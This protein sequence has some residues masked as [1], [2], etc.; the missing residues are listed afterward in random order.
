M[1]RLPDSLGFDADSDYHDSSASG[2]VRLRQGLA[3]PD[4]HIFVVDI[5]AVLQSWPL[6]AMAAIIAGVIVLLVPRALNYVVAVYLLFIG[7][8]G[9]LQYL[10][11]HAIRIEAVIALLAGGLI[12]LKPQIL[13]YVVGLYLVFIGLLEGDILRL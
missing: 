6:S 4:R 7:I 3:R 13:N 9:V 2:L 5:S 11:G 8:L 12:L 1:R 10:A